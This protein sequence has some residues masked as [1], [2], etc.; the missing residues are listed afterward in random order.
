MVRFDVLSAADMVNMF[1]LYL[2][3]SSDFWDYVLECWGAVV[4]GLIDE[5]GVEVSQVARVGALR[6]SLEL[7]RRTLSRRKKY[8]F[9]DLAKW[10]CI[11]SRHG[12]RTRAGLV[13]WVQAVRGPGSGEDSA[14]GSIGFSESRVN[15]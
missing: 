6:W 5:G 14:D 11:A 3:A 15:G 10:G 9:S 7:A 2:S 4:A 1:L 13:S 8:R 12:G